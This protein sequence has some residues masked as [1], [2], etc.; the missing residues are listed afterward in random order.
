VTRKEAL[1]EA[2][3]LILKLMSSG[4]EE[5]FAAARGPDGRV[6]QLRLVSSCLRARERLADKIMS[7]EI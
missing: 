5:I 2:E 7:G 3:S 1:E 6:D 4:D